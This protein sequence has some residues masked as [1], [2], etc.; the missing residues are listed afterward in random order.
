MNEKYVSWREFKAYMDSDQSTKLAISNSM[1]QIA[2]STKEA[3]KEARETNLILREQTIINENKHA[4]TEMQ[5]S[6]LRQKLQDNH[7]E[8]V[9]KITINEEILKDSLSVKSITT[10]AKWLL[11]IFITGAVTLAGAE[12]Y[13]KISNKI[14][15]KADKSQIKEAKK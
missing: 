4:Q 10:P 13:S 11:G 8:A 15:I 1:K 12:F 7:R 3:Q 5:L 9:E 14:E 2:A 6:E